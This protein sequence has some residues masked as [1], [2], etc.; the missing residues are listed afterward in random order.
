M[1]LS[2]KSVYKSYIKCQILDS[3]WIIHE[4]SDLSAEIIL[5]VAKKTIVESWFDRA[6][7]KK[8]FFVFPRNQLFNF[9][10][11]FSLLNK[12]TAVY[13]I[14]MISVFQD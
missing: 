10:V 7:L 2:G 14:E 1:N 4:L 5:I 9:L 3:I 6:T 12:S 13:N 11:D 8:F